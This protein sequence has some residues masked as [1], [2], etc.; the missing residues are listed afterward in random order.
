MKNWIKYNISTSP[1]VIKGVEKELKKVKNNCL[2]GLFYKEY[3]RNNYKINV[4]IKDLNTEDD[5]DNKNTLNS[6]D[7]A[8]SNIKPS[9]EQLRYA[10]E[11]TEEIKRI[12]IEQI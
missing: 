5:I 6:I 4:E 2:K 9:K 7:N 8:K 1:K 11:L 10:R 3:K 12:D